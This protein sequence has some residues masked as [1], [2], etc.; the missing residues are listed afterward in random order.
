MGR[1]FFGFRGDRKVFEEVAG[2]GTRPIAIEHR[3]FIRVRLSGWSIEPDQLC[4]AVWRDVESHRVD[5]RR[6]RAIQ[7]RIRN[8][9]RN[10][11]RSLSR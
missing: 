3:S 2:A 11:F 8:R 7:V 9:G 6:A 10:R 1:V 4:F 5:Q